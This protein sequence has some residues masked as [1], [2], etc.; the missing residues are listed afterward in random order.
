MYM[1]MLH[2]II[3][4]KHVKYNQ[5][6]TTLRTKPRESFA[7]FKHH[8]ESSFTLSQTGVFNYRLVTDIHTLLDINASVIGSTEGNETSWLAFCYETSNVLFIYNNAAI[9]HP[10]IVS[11]SNAVSLCGV[12]YGENQ[13]YLSVSTKG[14]YYINMGAGN[15]HSSV[16]IGLVINNDT[17]IPEYC[18]GKGHR[19]DTGSSQVTRG[20]LVELEALDKIGYKFISGQIENRYISLYRI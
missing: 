2:K 7:V 19:V 5:S 16:E 4:F 11:L 3:E 9:V 13:L 14:W 1:Y 6:C 8:E 15:V 18:L 17:I 12:S 20:F 10:T